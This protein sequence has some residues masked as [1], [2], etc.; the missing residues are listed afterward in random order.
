MGEAPEEEV[1]AV[2]HANGGPPPPAPGLDPE[3]Q[4]EE[5]YSTIIAE[6]EILKR[7]KADLQHQVVVIEERFARLQDSSVGRPCVAIL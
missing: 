5:R 7:E 4:L 3:L 1:I 2:E 6:N